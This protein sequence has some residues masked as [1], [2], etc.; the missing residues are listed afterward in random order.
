MMKRVESKGA[1]LFKLMI[2]TGCL[3][4][5]ALAKAAP[6]LDETRESPPREGPF[7]P[8]KDSTLFVFVAE[9]ER[10][11]PQIWHYRAVA[12]RRWP[13]CMSYDVLQ[14]GGWFPSTWH[15]NLALTREGA[16]YRVAV[17]QHGRQKFCD[18]RIDPYNALE[19]EVHQ[20]GDAPALHGQFSVNPNGSESTARV[21][22]RPLKTEDP[23]NNLTCSEAV[24]KVARDTVVTVFIEFDPLEAVQ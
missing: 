11:Q 24:V 4:N 5:G 13:L 9:D 22:C 23:Y 20:E 14:G 3:I 16:S 6:S 2:M 17:A 10:L 21:I 12:S 19:V 15:E 7:S 18:A 8:A 1:L